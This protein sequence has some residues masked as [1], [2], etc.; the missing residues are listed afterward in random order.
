MVSL[1]SL[2]FKKELYLI[3]CAVVF[4][5]IEKTIIE[6]DKVKTNGEI[7]EKNQNYTYILMYF[8]KFLTFLV[9]LIKSCF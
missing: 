2:N 7:F 5:L 6:D 8:G 1:L 9:Y 3:P 4:L